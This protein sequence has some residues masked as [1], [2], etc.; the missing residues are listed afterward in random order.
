MEAIVI[1]AKY[2]DYDSYTEALNDLTNQGVKHLG[3][4]NSGI[5]IPKG[6]YI[7]VY[8]NRSGSSTLLCDLTQR[9]CYSVDMGD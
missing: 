9:I 6:N 8:K 3:W 1:K 5:K 7:T 2:K 4:I